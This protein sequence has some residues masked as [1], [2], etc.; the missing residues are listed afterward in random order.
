MRLFGTSK[1]VLLTIGTVVALGIAAYAYWT[2]SGTGTGSATAA[3]PASLTVNQT[4]AAITNLYPGG[5]ARALSG[6]FDN[7]NT[8]PT[9][10]H[11]VTAAVHTFSSQSDGSKP[12]CTQADFAIAGTATVNAQVAAGNG[13]GSW[14]GLTVSMVNN[15]GANQDNCKGVS[16]QIDYTANGS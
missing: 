1:V 12:A 16:I 7:P 4:N 8:G 13:A 11:D 6:N 9:Y 14:S 15:A 2:G 3:T 10:V 5:P